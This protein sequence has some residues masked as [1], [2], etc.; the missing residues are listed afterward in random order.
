MPANN[1]A[2]LQ[3]AG[4][5]LTYNPTINSGDL[6]IRFSDGSNQQFSGLK[7]TTISCLVTLLSQPQRSFSNGYLTVNS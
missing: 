4:Y 2:I 7:D 6:Q 5:D 3:I 1:A